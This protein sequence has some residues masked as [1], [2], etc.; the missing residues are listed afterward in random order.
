MAQTIPSQIFSIGNAA[1]LSSMAL[2]T[3]C[4]YTITQEFPVSEG[5]FAQYRDCLVQPG[6]S[7]KASGTTHVEGSFFGRNLKKETLSIFKKE[8]YDKL[9]AGIRSKLGPQKN[10]SAL[11]VMEHSV[12]AEI[13]GLY[14]FLSTGESDTV[15]ALTAGTKETQPSIYHVSFTTDELHDYLKQVH[16]SIQSDGWESLAESAQE[17]HAAIQKDSAAAEE[18]KAAARGMYRTA[19]FIR[20]YLRAYFRN[21]KFVK[22]K[23]DPMTLDE[24]L[25][26]ELQARFPGLD[27]AALKNLA[28]NLFAKFSPDKFFFGE[29]GSG[30]FVSRGGATYQFPPLEATFDPFARRPITVSKIDFPT[31]G[32]DIV[33]VILE[34]TFDAHDLL[35]AVSSATGTM[36]SDEKERPLPPED[37]LPVNDPQKVADPRSGN[38]KEDEFG[39]VNQVASRMEAVS[40]AAV[41]QLVR[42]AGWVSLNNEALAK[43]LETFVGVTF[44]KVTEKAAW[45]RYSCNLDANKPG[46]ASQVAAT[47]VTDGQKVLV[48]VEVKVNMLFSD[49]KVLNAW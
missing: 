25:K 19:L 21:G 49:W 43:L 20:E 17:Y 46:S 31:V 30:G 16:E 40:S 23:L 9:L 38:L 27:G 39:K 44:R 42:G 3:G 41:G 35:P 22:F 33:R 10:P 48:K 8:Q 28:D 7:C 6:G 24:D 37:R 29:I 13:L 36:V 12:H 2:I 34:A 14:R 45:C 18:T 1:L 26:K 15:K 5:K 47:A 4:A 11:R 32:S